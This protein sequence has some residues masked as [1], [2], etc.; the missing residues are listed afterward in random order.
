MAAVWEIASCWCSIGS[1]VGC[2]VGW[3]GW[4]VGW[5]VGW[6]CWLVDVP[7][8]QKNLGLVG[9]SGVAWFYLR[10]FLSVWHDATQKHTSFHAG[11]VDFTVKIR[12]KKQ[13]H[14]WKTSKMGCNVWMWWSPQVNNS[15]ILGDSCFVW[16]FL[17]IY[18]KG[19]GKLG[20][21]WLCLMRFCMIHKKVKGLQ[22]KIQSKVL[23][24][25]CRVLCTFLF[26]YRHWDPEWQ[27]IANFSWM[28]NHHMFLGRSQKVCQN[29]ATLL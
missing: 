11:Q 28:N 24:P 17:I 6:T 1:W 5:L 10:I 3:V 18:R 8:S 27:Q 25:G 23:L 21:E 16:C 13:G 14:M 26:F 15:E 12:K 2:W 20:I 22:G 9:W 7:T 19:D 29:G 4:L